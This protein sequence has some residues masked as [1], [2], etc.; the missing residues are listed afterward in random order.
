MYATAFLNSMESAVLVVIS[1]MKR[2]GKEE[3]A[4]TLALWSWDEMD[5]EDSLIV[6]LETF[7]FLFLFFLSFLSG[8]LPTSHPLLSNRKD[9]N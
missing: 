9:T 7:I 3:K 8:L 1:L 6:K 4:S 2:K 5:A